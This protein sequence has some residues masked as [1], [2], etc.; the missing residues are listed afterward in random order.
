MFHCSNCWRLSYGF[1]F[2]HCFLVLSWWLSL[3]F[4][5]F[6]W[7][8]WAIFCGAKK[9]EETL[10][11]VVSSVCLASSNSQGLWGSCLR[12]K[13]KSM[14]GTKGRYTFWKDG[15]SA[16]LFQGEVLVCSKRS[17]SKNGRKPMESRFEWR[18]DF[19]QTHPKG[20]YQRLEQFAI[21]CETSLGWQREFS[22][23]RHAVDLKF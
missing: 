4:V 21:V 9:V 6:W 13:Q 22:V 1:G 15:T 11:R 17:R 12:G 18:A 10:Q 5:C 14:W 16:S 3:F 2:L 20:V 7:D 23:D 8:S 19:I